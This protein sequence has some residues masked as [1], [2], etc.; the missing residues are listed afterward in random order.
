MENI[1]SVSASFIIFICVSCLLHTVSCL[2][3]VYRDN[4]QHRLRHQSKEIRR[5]RDAVDRLSLQRKTDHI[6]LTNLQ[7]TMNEI[8]LNYELLYSKDNNIKN[9][10]VISLG[11][12]NLD[13][14]EEPSPNSLKKDKNYLEKENKVLEKLASEMTDL[15]DDLKDAIK[16][17]TSKDELLILRQEMDYMR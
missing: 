3:T 1:K 16:E 2:G 6:L 17:E 7:N 10:E 15:G 12:N 11:L 14:A 5:L 9:S 4:E 13:T 8:K